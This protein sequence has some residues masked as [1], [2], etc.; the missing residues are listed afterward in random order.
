MDPMGLPY[1]HWTH[2]FSYQVT[3]TTW[4]PEPDDPEDDP[5]DPPQDP[6][7]AAPMPR[8]FFEV[9]KIG[10]YTKEDVCVYT[11]GPQNHEKWRFYIPKIWVIPLKMMVVGSHGRYFGC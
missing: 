11:L 8:W 5:E 4:E 6:L 10:G 2:D 3:W 1:R 9:S 7:A